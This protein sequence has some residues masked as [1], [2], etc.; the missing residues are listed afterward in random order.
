MTINRQLTAERAREALAYDPLTGDFLWRTRPKRWAH[1]S[2]AGYVHHGYLSIMVDQ[3]S[4]MAHR[5]AWLIVTGDWPKHFIDHIDGNGLNNRFNNLRDV[6]LRVN[7]QNRRGIKRGKAGPQGVYVPKDGRRPR[8]QVV[9][10]GRAV[11]LGTFDT[12]EEAH[13]AY[14]EA[15]RRLHE[16]CTL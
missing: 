11:Y 12:P 7:N 16:G 1:K 5:L 9:V 8:A 2:S 14:V 4:Y 15:K 6:P 13:A 3:V 10:D